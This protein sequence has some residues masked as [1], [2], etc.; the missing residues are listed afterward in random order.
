VVDTFIQWR[1][2]QVRGAG[3]N[4]IELYGGEYDDKKSEWKTSLI[5]KPIT[6]DPEYLYTRVKRIMWNAKGKR[7]TTLTVILPHFSIGH[8]TN[9]LVVGPHGAGKSSLI[10]SFH[11]YIYPEK[12][13]LVANMGRGNYVGTYGYERFEMYKEGRRY[14]INDMPGTAVEVKKFPMGV[15]GYMKKLFR[16]LIV[17]KYSPTGSKGEPCIIEQ[18]GAKY[19][20]LPSGI[21]FSHLIFSFLQ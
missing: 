3:P 7:E 13:E 11:R 4:A 20:L 1:V 14:D 2:L 15:E 18:K 17:G 9:I 16:P 21:F 8:R 5:I 10:N 12:K 19:T 6:M